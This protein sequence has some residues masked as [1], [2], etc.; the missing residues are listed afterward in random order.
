MGPKNCHLIP[1][2]FVT[3]FFL[4]KKAVLVVMSPDAISKVSHCTTE[5]FEFLFSFFYAVALSQS[6]FFL[7]FECLF[8]SKH[9]FQKSI[10][11]IIKTLFS[12]VFNLLIFFSILYVREFVNLC[13]SLFL[14]FLKTLLKKTNKCNTLRRE[15]P[16]FSRRALRK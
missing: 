7:Q 13:K 2:V 11:S 15:I 8:D 12:P 1:L 16:Y 14:N 9:N 10:Y 5:C 4:K 6:T 3:K